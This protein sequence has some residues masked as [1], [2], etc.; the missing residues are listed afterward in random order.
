MEQKTSYIVIFTMFLF[1][2]RALNLAIS[3]EFPYLGG[4]G[5]VNSL[6]CEIQ[7]CV[8]DSVGKYLLSI[9]SESAGS[10]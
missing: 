3:T 9:N 4:G 2:L 1:D 10:H 8:S 5:E 7:R 6:N